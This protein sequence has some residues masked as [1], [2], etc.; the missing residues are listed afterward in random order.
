[1][2]RIEVVETSSDHRLL[3]LEGQV[4]GPW[5][6]EVD[7]SCEEALGASGKLTLDLADVTFIDRDGI[8][9]LRR[10]MH[11]GVMVLNSSPFIQT[12]LGA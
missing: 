3:R 2:L 7:R 6:A 1:M 9:L 5:V 8:E 10:L 4:L 11:V 12:Q